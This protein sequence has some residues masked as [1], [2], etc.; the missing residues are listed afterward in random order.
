MC[1][2]RIVAKETTSFNKAFEIKESFP[3]EVLGMELSRVNDPYFR[4]R[5]VQSSPLTTAK[6]EDRFG[7]SFLISQEDFATIANN[8][9]DY[10]EIAGRLYYVG[11]RA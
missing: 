7:F 9:E 5:P 2:I 3:F 4:L 11:G 8:T 10:F 6:F 1:L